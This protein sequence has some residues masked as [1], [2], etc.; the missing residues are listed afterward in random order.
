MLL[1]ISV[2]V[3]GIVGS[4]AVSDAQECG[5]A[6][7]FLA[8]GDMP[9]SDD[10][11]VKYR[12]LLQQSEEEEFAFLLHVGDTKSGGTPCTDQAFEHRR[13]EFRDY[14]NPIVY[15]IGDNEWTD[16]HYDGTDPIGRLTKLRELFF[17][18]ETVLRLHSLG[19]V[20]QSRQAEFAPYVENYRFT[21][22]RVLFVIVHVCGSGNNRRLDDPA[23]MQ[24]YTARNAANLAFLEESFGEAIRDQPAGVIIA[25]HANPDFGDRDGTGFVDTLQALEA[26]MSRYTKPVVCIH[27]DSHTHRIDHP[28][29]NEAGQAYQHFTRMEVFGSPNISGV[30][31]MVDS[32]DNAELFQF[33]PY[34]IQVE[35]AGP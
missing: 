29:K 33:E 13:D 31:V 26:F 2:F 6:F 5:A 27:G 12:R 1:R 14:P 24:E 7:R 10:E 35:N 23:A 21:K 11:D 9:Y 17:Q 4:V 16:C 15:T 32:R 22:S 30:T 8:I 3:L 25:I 19:A 28:L 34:T 20:H 18:D